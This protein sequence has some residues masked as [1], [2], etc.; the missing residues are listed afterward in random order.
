MKYA[1]RDDNNSRSKQRADPYH[2]TPQ[3][4]PDQRPV[5]GGKKAHQ[6]SPSRVVDGGPQDPG[7]Q[8][9]VHGREVIKPKQKGEEGD[10]VIEGMKHEGNGQTPSAIDP[11]HKEEDDEADDI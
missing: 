9:C 10:D 4:G 11:S 5:F 2:S 7:G 3:E 1:F 6:N 8:L